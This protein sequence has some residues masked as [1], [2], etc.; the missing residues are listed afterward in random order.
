MP[1]RHLINETRAPF[2]EAEITA[3]EKA[4]D[5]LNPGERTTYRNANANAIARHPADRILIVA[6]P[7]TG[8]SSIFKQRVLHWLE[9]TPNAK[10]LALSFVRKLV[11]DLRADIDNDAALSD[12]QKR[13]VDVFTLHKYARSIVEQNKGTREWGFRSHFRIIGQPWKGVVWHDVLLFANQKD[14]EPYSLSS[15]EKQLHE[16][17]FE[18][19][20]EWQ[21]IKEAYFT[22]C[23][24]Y[25][26]AGFADLIL[27]AKQALA[28]NPGLNQHQLYI[29]DEYQD[30]NASE[31]KLLNEITQAATATLTVGDDDQVLY[32][33]LKSGKAALIRAMYNSGET[34]NAML[35]F[36]GRCDF[37]IARAASHFIRQAADPASI[38]K[39]FLPISGADQ[40]AKVYVVASPGPA[41]ESTGA[42]LHRSDSLHL[43]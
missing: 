27:R 43:P 13:Q 10:V 19:S 30:F 29:V 7:G 24:L 15:F 18:P 23:K 1:I 33:E 12:D 20:A 4:L 17:Q 35:A 42:N 21:K 22:L 2:A 38:K 5:A 37:H 32:E 39:I 3:L 26:A 28:E 34:V 36:C 25:N 11:A 40:A 16:A 8:K 41:H 9:Q 31:E 6:G 14:V